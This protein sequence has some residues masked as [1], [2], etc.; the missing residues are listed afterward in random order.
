MVDVVHISLLV[1]N[2]LGQTEYFF[3]VFSFLRNELTFLNL[4]LRYV[5][6]D[7]V[8]SSCMLSLFFNENTSSNKDGWLRCLLFCFVYSSRPRGNKIIKPYLAQLS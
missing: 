5:L 6:F 1:Y 7:D 8:L 3:L 2:R 4:L